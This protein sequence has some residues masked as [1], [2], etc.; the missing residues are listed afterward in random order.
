[1]EQDLTRRRGADRLRARFARSVRHGFVAAAAAGNVVA[2]RLNEHLRAQQRQSRAKL[3]HLAD[4]DGLTGLANHGLL[5]RRLR[6]ALAEL[7]PRG[8]CVAILCIDV[9]NLKLTNDSLGHEAGDFVLVELGRRLRSQ[10]RN[11][12][13]LARIGG[14]EF[15]GVC[16]GV[17]DSSSA[18]QI[19][20]RIAESLEAPFVIAGHERFVTCCVGIAVAAG[21]GDDP[22][23]LIR[24]ADAALDRA[25]TNGR[26]RFQLVDDEILSV[27]DD[28]HSLGRDLHVAVQERTF[29]LHYQ[30]IVHLETG[31]IAGVEALLR[32]E[33]PTRGTVP[34][35]DFIAAAETSGLIVP[36]G[37]WAL[38]EA[39][40]Q[41]ARWRSA[42]QDHVPV[43]MFANASPREITHPG[44]LDTVRAAL[45]STGVDP[46][47]LLI[48]VTEHA[49]MEE[50]DA[51]DALVA[52]KQMGVRIVLDDF[53]TGHSS[54]SQLARFPV[55]LL[56]LDRSFVSAGAESAGEA[57]ILDAVVRM[58]G[59]LGMP[60][61][62]EGVETQSQLE[63]LRAHGLELAQ[64]YH[65]AR[66]QPA[67]S[68][69][70]L[71]RRERPF[72]DLV[73]DATRTAR[74]P[75]PRDD[76]HDAPP[77]WP[78]IERVALPIGSA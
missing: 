12:D 33:H 52:L 10:L 74:R 62:A 69:T 5:M 18:A 24:Q 4:H 55:E 44:F 70:A 26:S 61:V 40:M 25:K 54:L 9:D 8:G 17:E 65:F 78:V 58:A 49:L 56:K 7:P 30:P 46:R 72:A 21:A 16:R 59:G 31:A 45:A 47:Q 51:M 75:V 73:P 14:D 37:R 57:T 3:A 38:R 34:A 32:W 36:I 1:M 60:L 67:D 2:W 43:A 22:E 11:G 6:E 13:T 23:T 48:E 19:G 76:A 63:N 71:L 77:A 27:A 15:V 20:A 39:C 53:G 28:R 41:A 35:G 66:P 42:L 68:L 64:G 29:S 50:R